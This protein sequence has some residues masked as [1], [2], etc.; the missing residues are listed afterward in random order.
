MVLMFDIPSVEYTT[1][2]MGCSISPIGGIRC[3]PKAFPKDVIGS[4]SFP[5]N[6]HI[7]HGQFD[8]FLQVPPIPQYCLHLPNHVQCSCILEFDGASKGNPGQAGA[9]A[10]LRAANG[11]MN[12]IPPIFSQKSLCYFIECT[13]GVSRGWLPFVADEQQEG[14]MAL[15]VASGDGEVTAAS[16]DGGGEVAVVIDGEVMVASGGE[17]CRS[18]KRGQPRKELE[19]LMAMAESSTRQKHARGR[20]KGIGKWQRMNAYLV[21]NP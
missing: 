2:A 6:P 15:T 4:T 12:K 3:R 14:T 8:N 5:V 9:G 16:G 21:R 18:K 20:P 13:Y 1:S 10:V 11:S 7:K 17:E 19:E